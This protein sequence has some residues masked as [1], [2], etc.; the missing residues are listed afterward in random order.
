KERAQ[1]CAQADRE[2]ITWFHRAQAPIELAPVAM[3]KAPTSRGCD[4]SNAV[5][6]VSVVVRATLPQLV[7]RGIRLVGDS[8]GRHRSGG[9]IH[10]LTRWISA[11]DIGATPA[12]R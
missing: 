7:L 4:A 3:G 8:I 11:T 6:M 12:C 1:G 5:A 2:P 10:L 9:H